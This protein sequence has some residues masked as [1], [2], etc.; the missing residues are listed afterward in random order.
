[1][2]ASNASAHCVII[3]PAFNEAADIG[4]VIAEIKRSCSY[5]IVV[6]DDCSDD[7]TPTRARGAG[8]IV[9]PL[10]LR[11][12]AWSAIQTGLQFAQA[13]GFR[14]AI[15]LDADGQHPAAAIPLLLAPIHA[16][17][18]DL[19]IGNC[20]QRGST[21]R[22]LAW[23]LMRGVSRLAV[24]DITS[25]LRAY[26]TPAIDLLVDDAATLLEYQDLGVLILAQA[27]GLR[28]AEVPVM[29]RQRRSGISRIFASW[30]LVAYYMVC[31][32]ILGFSKRR[33]RNTKSRD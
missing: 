5:P 26:S 1:V 21:P 24:D 3:I 28:I 31:T 7:D 4:A 23:Q 14:C 29:M 30:T 15:T 8:A 17:A 9:L 16:G 12:G 2:S 18:A 33:L 6:V 20:T 32:L 10:C 19:V 22:R 11:L 27:A 25:G 13:E